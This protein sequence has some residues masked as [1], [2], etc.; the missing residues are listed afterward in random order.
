MTRDASGIDQATAAVEGAADGLADGIERH[1]LREH[2]GHLAQTAAPIA[3]RGSRSERLRATLERAD[4]KVTRAVD[5]TRLK[6]RALAESARRAR[7][8]PRHVQ[9]HLQR[10]GKAYAG[11]LAAG[12]VRY[13]AAAFVGLIALVVF[14]VALVQGL[15]EAWGKPWGTFTV[16]GAYAIAALVLAVSGQGRAAA[17]KAQAKVH[18][19]DARQELR[20]V[21]EPLRTRWSDGPGLSAVVPPPASSSTFQPLAGD[22]PAATAHADAFRTSLSPSAPAARPAQGD[23]PFRDV[24]T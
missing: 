5:K 20:D 12:L 23:D 14:T 22:G 9:E 13:A 16:A 11:G 10:A 17:G 1:G 8:A 6:A 2:A 4:E 3:Q 18:L 7:H 19:A 15:N 21:A 24:K